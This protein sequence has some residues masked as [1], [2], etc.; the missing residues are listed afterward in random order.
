[1]QIKHL[2]NKSIDYILWDKCISESINQLTYAFSWYLDIVSPNWEALVSENYEYIMPIPIKRKLR[3]PYIVQPSLAQ[4]LGIFSKT[5]ID[6]KITTDFIKQLPSLSYELNLNYQNFHSDG[7]SIPNY[8]LE[9][10]RNY[11]EISSY[12]SKNT[13]RNLEKSIN[14]NLLVKSD[15]AL[16]DFLSFYK[17]VNKDF[18]FPQQ[19]LINQLLEKGISQGAMTLYGI[20]K[21]EV[22][23]AAFCAL[24][25]SNRITYIL[26][27]S[28][29]EGKSCSAMFQL[30]DT[31]IKNN[32]EKEI[33]FD[34]EGSR[35]EGIARFFKGFGAINQPYY[36]IK[37]LRPAFLI[38]KI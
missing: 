26:P 24:Y 18:I 9:L 10:N 2:Q 30:I 21:D 8:I 25:S 35:N 7:I 4:Q 16:Q 1:M 23:I 28:N 17:E 31:V 5:N 11:N 6:E 3:V 13:Q 19:N 29:K 27:A 22:L 15:I 14:S 38:G 37:R 36:I 34:F 12:Y 32:A 20:Y 33:I